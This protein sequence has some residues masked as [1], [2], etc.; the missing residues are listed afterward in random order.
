MERKRILGID[1]G[2]AI[3]G[4]AIVD[5]IQSRIELSSCGAVTTEKTSSIE[6]RLLIIYNELKKLIAA[7]SPTSMAIEQLFFASNAKTAIEVSEARGVIVL[8]A[9]QAGIPVISYSPLQVKRTLT[10][11]GHADKKQ[12]QFMLT[13]TLKIKK[14]PQPDDVADAVAVALTHAYTHVL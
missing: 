10:G 4:W 2:Y 9:A 5:K 14:A 13:K 12:V 6:Q 3:V 1:P 11:D 7:Y 8:T